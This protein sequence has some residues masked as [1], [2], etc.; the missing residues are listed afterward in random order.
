MFLLNWT[1][2]VWDFSK[3]NIIPDLFIKRRFN[4]ITIHYLYLIGMSLL[5][6]VILYGIGGMAYI[7]A[8]FFASGSA[9]QS[10]LNT[11]DVNTLK[12]GQQA[13][14]YLGAMLCNPI[15]VHS[16]VVFVR[17]YWFEK[18]FKDV[19]MEA[20]KLRRTRSKTRA[21]TFSKE[22]PEQGPES[23]GVKER[24]KQIIHN[25]TALLRRQTQSK[26]TEKDE[27][28]RETN[29]KAVESS[30]SS[31]QERGQAEL[32][33]HDDHL[34]L[35]TT[36]STDDVRLPQL[37]SPEQHI[38]FLE[39]QRNPD[40]A[41]TLR[42]PSPR[43]FERGS[44]PENIPDHVDGVLLRQITSEPNLPSSSE[45][46]SVELNPRPEAGATH[47]TIDEP[48]PRFLRDRN[49][50]STTF[51]RLNTRQSTLPQNQDGVEPGLYRRP[52][53]S[54]T[55]RTLRR[56]NTAR[57]MEPA[58][59]LSWQP[60]IGRNSFFFDLTEE[61][62]EE[63]GGIEYRALK[64][65][66]LILVGYFFFFHFL[67]VICLTPWIVRSRTYS[68]V[69]QA[70]SQNRVW[71]GFFTSASSFNDL[72]F[73]LTPDSMLSFNKAV[74]PLLIMTFLIVI[75]NTGFP[76]M[77]RFVIWAISKV[78]S[79]GTPLWEE[80][81][82]LLDHPRRCF[83]L[84][85]PGHAT[86]VLFAI[87]VVLNGVDLIFFII[88]DLNDPIVTQLPGGI[89][90]LDGLFQAASTRTAGFA[91]VNLA[92]LH[93]AIQVSYLVMMYISVFPIAISM[94]RT[95]VYEEKSL[96]IYNSP[97]EEEDDEK[98][99]SYVG[100]HLR[101]QLSFDLWYVFL[102]M[103]IIA[104]VEGSRLENTNEYAFTLFSVLFEIVS[105][106]GTVGLSLGYP[107]ANT[108]FSGQF[109]TLSKLVIIA[110]QIRGRHRGLPYELDRAILLPSESLQ[111]KE[112]KEGN[113]I[114][115]RRRRSSAGQSMMSAVDGNMEG[116][117]FRAE[118]GMASGQNAGESEQYQLRPR[119]NTNRTLGSIAS[120][121]EQ[122][123]HTHHS[124]HGHPRHVI[125]NA[126]YK[127]ST[128]DNIDPIKEEKGSE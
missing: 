18:R 46:R 94:R 66:A 27:D 107:T 25:A 43:E 47:I 122:Q 99:A 13:M 112:I 114:V 86:W 34:R 108:S 38:R 54:S 81:Q 6:S 58:P 68:A 40:D 116:Q 73:T 119:T 76:C 32:E 41:T 121:S 20:R 62:R 14:L 82:F 48:E 78:V 44:R 31:N 125:G 4:F 63:L 89:R 93:P 101:R 109:R 123:Q 3:R 118:T 15:V 75:G 83:T 120:G 8:L 36:R 30:N 56:S 98:E 33:K 57:T 91:V 24:G 22:D 84:L 96:G 11:V 95:N 9:T 117:H 7:D 50:K 74:F 80:L 115:L 71:W 104:I 35:Q 65:L 87:L 12:T 111:Q 42:I 60:T 113:R 92:E 126:M 19:V 110:M 124:H 100:A 103:F 64:T 45:K 102:G 106:Y 55:F 53:R 17:L 88:L 72:G 70:V 77:L 90:F 5:L 85:F 23:L 1:Q 67:G 21:N 37:L 29:G 97:N 61:Q 26:E 28:V 10:G 51:P 69:V 16:F 105:A 79:K 2:D 128:L 39:N 49:D 127:L 59:Y 52:T